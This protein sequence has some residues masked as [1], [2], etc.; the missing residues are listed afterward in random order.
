[1][2]STKLWEEIQSGT[3]QPGTQLPTETQL[4]ERFGVNRL[5]VRQAISEL[6]HLGAI[7]IRRGVG[8]FVAAPPDLVEIAYSVPMQRQVQDSV[9]DANDAREKRPTPHVARVREQYVTFHETPDQDMENAAKEMQCEVSTIFRLDTLMVRNDIPWIVNTYWLD[10]KYEDVVGYVRSGGKVV[11]T[12]LN[13]LSLELHYSWR[14]FSAIGAGYDEANL[15]QIQLGTPLLVRDGVTED[16]SRHPIFYVRR[17]IRGETAKFVLR[18][19][20]K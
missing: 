11:S 19:R 15:L 13:E 9:I 10:R 7:E 6:Q 20:E 1:M 18:Y 8:T 4:S 14:A 5:T 17:R 3:I 2:I 16:A 12:L